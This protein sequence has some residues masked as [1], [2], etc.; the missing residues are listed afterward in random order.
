MA[1]AR[2]SRPQDGRHAPPLEPD[3]AGLASARALQVQIAEERV[4]EASAF[5][6]DPAHLARS[7]RAALEQA[8]GPR[9]AAF[10]ALGQGFG[11]TA[12]PGELP[13]PHL[14]QGGLPP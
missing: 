5:C 6:S 12:E 9:V 3:S 13:E 8:A 14:R 10:V 2:T 4:A 1:H 11:L 7:E